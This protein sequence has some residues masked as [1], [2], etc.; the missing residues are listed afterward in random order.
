MEFGCSFF[1]TDVLSWFL[2]QHLT[3]KKAFF[4]RF[5]RF[6]YLLFPPSSYRIIETPGRERVKMRDPGLLDFARGVRK[7][8]PVNSHFCGYY[9]VA[10]DVFFKKN[11]KWIHFIHSKHMKLTILCVSFNTEVNGDK[12]LWCAPYKKSRNEDSPP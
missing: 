9:L 8:K 3:I 7:R 4:S 6:L 2:S 10:G 5:H 11:I 1:V 12:Q